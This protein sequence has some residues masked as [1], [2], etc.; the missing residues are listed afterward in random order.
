MRIIRVGYQD[1]TFYATIEN[2]M[3]HCLDRKLGLAA[4]VPLEQARLLPL[5][6]PTKIICLAV[7]YLAHGHEI[8]HEI[9]EVPRLFFKPPSALIMHQEPI[10][11]PAASLHV[12]YE[13]ELAV[14]MGRF[15]RD[16]EPEEAPN[17]VFG[18][19]CANDVTARDLQKKD[20]LFG[21]AKGF[22]TFAPVGPW[23]ETEVGDLGN[24]SVKTF[25]NNELRQQGNT[26][27]MIFSTFE[28]ISF[29]SKIMTLVPGDVILTGTP[30]GVGPLSP[31]DEV[32][33]EIE[34]VGRLTNP[35]RHQEH[36]AG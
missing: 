34:N 13:A 29:V 26:K 14:V 27:D 21:R 18:Y 35:V 15:C 24:L 16:V 30:E 5:V 3:L 36:L 11:L 28:I 31:G 10:V 2:G 23:I 33:V 17:Y 6:S 25:V 20:V 19:T 22:D 1:K 4:P 32:T 9:P 8:K 7:N 12:D